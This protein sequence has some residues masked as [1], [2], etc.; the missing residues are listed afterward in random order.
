MLGKVM[1]IARSRDDIIDASKKKRMDE[2]SMK[3][4]EMGGLGAIKWILM[5]FNIW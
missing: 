1:K 2:T 5:W 4:S 3:I